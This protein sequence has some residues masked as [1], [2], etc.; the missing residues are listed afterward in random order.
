MGV[1]SAAWAQDKPVPETEELTV[2]GRKLQPFEKYRD[3]QN[4]YFNDL[5]LKFGDPKQSTYPPSPLLAP[6]K[7]GYQNSFDPQTWQFH[8]GLRDPIRSHLGEIGIMVI[9]R[10]RSWD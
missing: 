2:L 4:S 7:D 10:G 1:A 5:H 8:N 9:T 6:A 3:L